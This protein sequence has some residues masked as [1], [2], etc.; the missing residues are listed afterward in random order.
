MQ[1]AK[2]LALWRECSRRKH[3]V[4]DT[5]E[6]EFMDGFQKILQNHQ[7]LGGIFFISTNSDKK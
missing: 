3:F 5:P 4:L 1:K 7:R 6:A 2:T